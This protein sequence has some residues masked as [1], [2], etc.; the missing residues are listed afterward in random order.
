LTT[1][2]RGSCHSDVSSSPDKNVLPSSETANVTPPA[3]DLLL[4]KTFA[5][6]WQFHPFSPPLNILPTASVA[7]Y[8]NAYFPNG[9]PLPFLQNFS[10]LAA[11]PQSSDLTTSKTSI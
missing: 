2:S 3:D 10:H 1:S 4:S 7:P 6:A 9:S 11:S 8:P 5:N